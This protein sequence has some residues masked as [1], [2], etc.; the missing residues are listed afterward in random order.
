MDRIHRLNDNITS[1][2]DS[3]Y[4]DD[5]SEHNEDDDAASSQ[6]SNETSS[7]FSIR[8]FESDDFIP[9]TDGEYIDQRTSSESSS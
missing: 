2:N 4:E 1:Q 9:K 7:N 6:A 5:S 8:N 3:I